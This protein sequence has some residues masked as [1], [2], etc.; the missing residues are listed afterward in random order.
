M[1]GAFADP[2][3]AYPAGLGRRLMAR[4]VD[5]LLP[6][7][8]AV[9]VALPLVGQAQ[10]H[11]DE[12]IDAAERAG[13]TETIWL[14]DG[15]TGGYLALVLGVFLGAG[16]LLE[17]LP[18]AFWGRTLGK[19]MFRLR[20]L[21]VASQEKPAFGAATL[22]WLVYSLLSLLVVGVVSLLMGVRDRPWRQAWHDKAAHTFVAGAKRPD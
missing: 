17:A 4:I 10:D 2:G 9:A 18:T 22:R 3:Q 6:L 12:Q 21:D 8:A 13:V 7:G 20:V 19:A 15:T 16:L 1:I 11:I 5:S 14:I